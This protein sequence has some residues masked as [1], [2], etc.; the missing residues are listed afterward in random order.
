MTADELAEWK[1]RG[2]AAPVVV[3]VHGARSV[4]PL[5]PEAMR[6]KAV[7]AREVGCCAGC[8]FARQDVAVCRRAAAAAVRAGFEDCEEGAVYVLVAVDPRQLPISEEL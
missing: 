2:G 1:R 7:A 5:E 6:F 3:T 8:V 4:A